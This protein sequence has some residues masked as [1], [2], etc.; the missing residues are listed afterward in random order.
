MAKRLFIGNLSY[1]STDDSLRKA[2]EAFGT[3]V[4]ATII[5]NR[6]TGQSKGF[7]FVEMSTDAEAAKAVAELNGKPLDGRPLT[8]NEA[9]ERTEE[10]GN[11]GGRP[12]EHHAPAPEATNDQ[13]V[14]E[15][16]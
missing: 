9:R 5:T 13:P 11:G 3:V 4:D 14:D 15:I 8:V 12:T 16:K 6:H 10:S 2:F 1:S 7:G